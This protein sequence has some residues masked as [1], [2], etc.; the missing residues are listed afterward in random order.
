MGLERSRL[1]D[2]PRVHLL[3]P[4]AQLPARTV[5]EPE[6]SYQALLKPP[7]G[8]SVH[9]K[10]LRALAKGTSVVKS[11]RSNMEIE[12][13]T[14]SNPNIFR[15]SVVCISFSVRCPYIRSAMTKASAPALDTQ[16]L[17]SATLQNIMCPTGKGDGDAVSAVR[18]CVSRSS[19]APVPI[20]G[21][22]WLTGKA[23]VENA[24][25]RHHVAVARC[26]NGSEHRR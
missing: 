26:W 20:G 23:Q 5:P 2:L 9:R 21:R 7:T 13:R 15:Q 19:E 12:T 4:Q 25:Q 24:W 16:K 3:H 6:K 10:Y 14:W 1:G 22:E 8:D 17:P 11:N 18:G